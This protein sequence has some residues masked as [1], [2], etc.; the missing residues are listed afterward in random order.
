MNRLEEKYTSTTAKL[1]KQYDRF[2]EWEQ[3]VLR[4][5]SLQL[6]PTDKCNLNCDFCSVKFR[7][8][9]EMEFQDIQKAV[10]ALVRKGLKTVELTGG[11]DPTCYKQVE[12]LIDFL[13]DQGL[14]IGFITNGL[15]LMKNVSRQHLDMLT[16]LRVSMNCLDYVD[17]V[18]LPDLGSDT[19]LGFSYVVNSRMIPQTIERIFS[20]MAKH[21]VEYLRVVPDCLT[22]ESM[23]ESKRMAQEMGLID[24]SGVFFQTKRYEVPHHCRIGYLKPY[25]APDGYIYHCS[26]NP[27]ILRKFNPD[28]RMGYWTEIDT[29]WQEPY[30]A[31]DTKNCVEGKCFFKEHNDFLDLFDMP[32]AHRNFV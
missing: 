28:F 5:I 31:F 30:T 13:H 19:L 26:A 8:G 23:E 32:I 11:G 9:D 4:P 12:P 7:E 20:Y 3:G 6:A 22:T 17:E 18:N 21:G 2:E 27:L 16:W 1:L 10:L 29:I 24:R 25:L 14:Q 15:A